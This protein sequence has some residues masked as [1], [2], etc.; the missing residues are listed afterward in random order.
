MRTAHRPA[1]ARVP[2]VSAEN[3]IL[4]AGD[5]HCHVSPPDH[6]SHVHR[7]LDETYALAKREGLDF[8]V[9]TPHVWARF[10]QERELRAFQIESQRYLH[11]AI[12][13]QPRDVMFIAGFEYTDGRYGHVGMAF[14]DVEEALRASP[15]ED[16]QDH[17]EHFIEEWVRRG[18]LLT[19]NHPFMTPVVSVFPAAREN[20]S[21]RPFTEPAL[22]VPE[23]IAVVQ[24]LAHGYE[25][26]NMM[27]S[28]L[29]D[30]WVLS[31]RTASIWKTVRYLDDEVARQRRRLTPVGGSDSHD[32]FLR[33][34]TFVLA[35]D[36]S[37]KG[38][39]DAIRSGRTCVRDPHACTLRVRAGA[40]EVGVGGTL[41]GVL[42]IEVTAGGRENFVFANGELIGQPRAGE[43]VTH[44]VPNICSVVRAYTDRGFS[45][46]VYV[47]CGIEDGQQ[48]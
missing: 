26:Y 17:P 7:G 43:F 32:S 38:I 33:P 19:I 25:I 12:A 48:R 4:L 6:P 37:E 15:V 2:I 35:K 27:V 8:V 18:G 11:A 20:M 23:D 3:Y 29:R 9:L 13:A 14:A 31:D 45:A 36:R 28:Q 10:Q 42:T 1:D 46:P 16:A 5:M 21:W 30:G 24:R 22:A 44:D 47:N 40:R 34:T 41:E 39:A